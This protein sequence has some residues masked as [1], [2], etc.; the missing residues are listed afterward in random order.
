[1]LK[2]VLKDIELT[3]KS[4]IELKKGRYIFKVDIRST[5]PEIKRAVSQLFG[6][7]VAQVRTLIRK[8]KKK[9]GMAKAGVRFG[10][11]SS[12]KKA[13]VRLFP[14]EQISLPRKEEK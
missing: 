8:K 9:R 2:R 6:V 1:M 10:Y 12:Y 14:G 3:P 5:K 7:K 4:S 11:G 13:I